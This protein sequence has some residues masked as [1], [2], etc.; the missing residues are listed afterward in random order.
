MSGILTLG[1]TWTPPFGESFE[2]VIAELPAHKRVDLGCALQF[3]A[4]D[5]KY[6]NDHSPE[7]EKDESNSLIFFF[8]HLLSRLQA[9][10]TVPAIEIGEYAKSLK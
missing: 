10:G 7:I 1:N 3:G 9:L 2:S 8:L 4:F 6:F 5:V